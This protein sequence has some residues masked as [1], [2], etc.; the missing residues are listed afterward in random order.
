MAV[1]SGSSPASVNNDETE[2]T[3]HTAESV[4]TATAAVSVI[5]DKADVG[6]LG[7]LC[8]DQHVDPD[9]ALAMVAECTR[10]VIERTS[11]E[12]K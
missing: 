5:D 8:A 2:I 3:P 9:E 1:L 11:S 10:F 7:Q 12:G 6:E 4:E